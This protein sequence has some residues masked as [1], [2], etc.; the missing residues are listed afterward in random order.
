MNLLLNII[1]KTYI[2]IRRLL[3][4]T[5]LLTV[6][7]FI[8]KGQ[9]INLN[10][11]VREYVYAI[12]HYSTKGNRDVEDKTTQFL[13]NTNNM[14]IAVYTC[15]VGNYDNIIEPQIIEPGIDYYVF[16]DQECLINSKW[17][18]IDI[19]H[20]EDY[21]NLSSIKLNRK[22]KMLP[23]IYLPDY[24]YSIY[25]DGNIE[26][27]GRILPQIKE[28][29]NCGLGI[30]YHR[31]RD[32]I[33]DELVRVAYLRKAKIAIAREQIKAYKKDGYPRHNGL[34]ENT[35]LIRKHSDMS[36]RDL[37]ESW[38]KEFL[39]YPTRDQLSLPYIIWKQGYD[40]R[41]IHI[42]GMNINKSKTFKRVRSHF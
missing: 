34:Y 14:R 38:W 23:F 17:T 30:H 26:I 13:L 37:M 12:T 36:T 16:T 40:R 25:I 6:F 9:L 21:K 10:N 31:T 20:F 19:T 32:C 4:K 18:K 8:R 39:L 15:I 3:S 24:D 11:Y 42:L 35:V 28:M 27:T 7:Y 1:N 2:I 5:F 22:I 33:Y 29:E 41:N